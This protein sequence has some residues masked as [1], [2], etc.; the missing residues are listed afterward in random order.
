[1]LSIHEKSIILTSLQL[2]FAAAA[3]GTSIHLLKTRSSEFPRHYIVFMA[4]SDITVPIAIITGIVVVSKEDTRENSR[5]FIDW[6]V[7]LLAMVTVILMGVV[8]IV[9]DYLSILLT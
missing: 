7:D 6:L 2:F 5:S 8:C 1:V 4:L 9:P 3:M